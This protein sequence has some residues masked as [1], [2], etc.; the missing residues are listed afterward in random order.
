MGTAFSGASVHRL[1]TSD[2]TNKGV[3]SCSIRKSMDNGSGNEESSWSKCLIS[4]ENSQLKVLSEFGD[5]YVPLDSNF[6]I[7]CEVK[8]ELVF[9]FQYVKEYRYEDWC[10]R[11][12][13]SNDFEFWTQLIKEAKRP[14]W[15]LSKTC[16][17]CTKKFSPIMRRHHCRKCGASVCSGCSPVKTTLPELNYNCLVR[18]CSDCEESLRPKRSSSLHFT[19]NFKK[20]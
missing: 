11:V 16:E 10:V 15:H 6:E 2:K 5:L 3:L 4:V 8:D 1:Q 9:V 18:V 12:E 19:P 7:V 13:L 14:E 17:V 20:S